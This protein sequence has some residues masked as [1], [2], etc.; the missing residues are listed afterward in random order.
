MTLP[1]DD[2]YHVVMQLITWDRTH[3]EAS[4]KE[5][6]AVLLTGKLDLEEL[7][8]LEY[9]MVGWVPVFA[10]KLDAEEY[11]AN[12]APTAHVLEVGRRFEEP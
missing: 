11:Q 5:R 9:K 4:L 2:N 7:T 3:I 12:E 1:Q 6:L 10:N 8:G